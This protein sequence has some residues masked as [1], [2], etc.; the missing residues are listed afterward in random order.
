[1]TGLFSRLVVKDTGWKEMRAALLKLKHGK[2]YAVAGIIGEKAK[3]PHGAA[4]APAGALSN[5]DLGL[6]HEF[7]APSVGIPERSFLRA[8]FEANRA[9]YIANLNKA[10]QAVFERRL[11]VKVALGLVGAQMAGD[12][13]LAIAKG[14]PPPNSPATVARKGSSKPLIDTGQL[15]QAISS[16]VVIG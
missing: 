10:L 9:K 1:M 15:R 13:Q 16:D 4:D 12:M 11:T 5:V 7:G 6:I 2:S 8:P 14:I 3:E